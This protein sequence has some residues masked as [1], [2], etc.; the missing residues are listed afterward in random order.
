MQ[1]RA[2]LAG[3][4][5]GRRRDV[6]RLWVSRGGGRDL[7][8]RGLASQLSDDWVRRLLGEPIWWSRPRLRLMMSASDAARRTRWYLGKA[9]TEA[10]LC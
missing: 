7:R 8:V 10:L 3:N 1:R 6:E 9:S 4:T 2:S 5:A